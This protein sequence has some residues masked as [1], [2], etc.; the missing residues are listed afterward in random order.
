MSEKKYKIAVLGSGGVGKT[1][2][3]LR[4]TRQTFDPEYIPT[5][6]DYFEKN[7]TIDNKCYTMNIIDTAGQ[8]EM[9]G[10]TD[11]AIQDA[12]AFIITY[13][14]T[15]MM[16]FSEANKYHEKILQFNNGNPEVKIV[17]VGNKCDLNEERAVPKAEGE[18]LAKRWNAPFFEA[19][20]KQNI[21][22]SEA[23]DAALGLFLGTGKNPEKGCC[24]LI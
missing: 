10:I 7:T 6:Q 13:S 14:I 16:S 18:D 2:L 19:S 9:Q 21:N 5:I 22:V 1:C 23:F 11:I 20:A 3:I 8:D 17:L 24:N 15:S 4:L 12:E